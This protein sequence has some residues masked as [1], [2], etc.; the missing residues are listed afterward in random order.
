MITRKYRFNR[1]PRV[2]FHGTFT[3]DTEGAP[4]SLED[5]KSITMACDWKEECVYATLW[6]LW[7][8]K[9]RGI[10]ALVAQWE[11]PEN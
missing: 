11:D 2:E 7:V 4:R 5:L 6:E 8:E 10:W 3:T 1:L 9:D